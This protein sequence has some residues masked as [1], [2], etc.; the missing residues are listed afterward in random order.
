MKSKEYW[1]TVGSKK[2]YLLRYS[3]GEIALLIIYIALISFILYEAPDSLFLLFVIVGGA[4]WFI[5]GEITRARK[6]T[7]SPICRL[8]D[9][10]IALDHDRK[11]VPWEK[12]NRIIWRPT[13]HETI[14]FYK[15]R[16]KTKYTIL[17]I[18]HERPVFIYRKWME[19]ED[20]FFENLKAICDEHSIPFFVADDGLFSYT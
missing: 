14:V 17:S 10:F 9:E 1:S 6:I 19:D 12:V 20:I 16:P 18:M 2:E 11:I 5:R 4:I 3:K 13:K 8:T 15:V 7:S